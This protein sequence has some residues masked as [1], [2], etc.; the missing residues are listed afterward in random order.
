MNLDA[1]YEAVDAEKLTMWLKKSL[2]E[3]GVSSVEKLKDD[4]VVES[5]ARSTYKRIPLVPVRAA[6]KC[7]IGE[8][9]FHRF[10]FQV[11]D[12]MVSTDS[13]DLS[14]LSPAE[15]KRMLSHNT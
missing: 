6:I 12:K 15:I 13:L 4:R 8:Q 11:R 3:L 7:T 1:L 14:W 10:V 5:V 2:T 9:G